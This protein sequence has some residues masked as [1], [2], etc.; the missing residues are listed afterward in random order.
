[1]QRADANQGLVNGKSEASPRPGLFKV[2]N[3]VV[4]GHH[5][6]LQPAITDRLCSAFLNKLP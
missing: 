3:A 2:M 1:M 6:Q 5:V 4:L